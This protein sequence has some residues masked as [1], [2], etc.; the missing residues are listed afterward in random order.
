[1]GE[2]TFLLLRNFAAREKDGEMPREGFPEKA[3]D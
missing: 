3:V 1:M 2:I